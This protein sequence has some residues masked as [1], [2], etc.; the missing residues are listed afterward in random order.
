M[1]SE[2]FIII[3]HF[4]ISLFIS[5]NTLPL[6]RFCVI[7]IWPKHLLF[8][9]YIIFILFPGPTWVLS[10][11]LFP[12]GRLREGDGAGVCWVV[13]SVGFTFGQTKEALL[14]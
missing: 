6:K 4:L 1:S 2:E 10:L 7:L 8:T 9:C 12:I 5:A 14:A 3:F 13:L 11:F